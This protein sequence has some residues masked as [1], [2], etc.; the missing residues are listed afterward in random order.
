VW[1]GSC[2]RQRGRQASIDGHADG[3]AATLG[4]LLRR[5]IW[6]GQLIKLYIIAYLI[7][8][9]LTEFV[10]PDPVLALGLTGYQWACLGL[11]PVFIALWVRD[12]QTALAR[13]TAR[14]AEPPRSGAAQE[15]LDRFSELRLAWWLASRP[16]DPG[17]HP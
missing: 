2:H 8:R 15:L 5:G 4:E 16:R 3:R 9:F 7:Y 13:E 11:I 17:A 1:V 6:R 12:T 14:A 10:R